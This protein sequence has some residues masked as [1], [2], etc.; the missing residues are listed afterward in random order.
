MAVTGG[1]GAFAGARGSVDGR[2]HD[3]RIDVTVR[4]VDQPPR[5]RGPAGSG[6]PS[7]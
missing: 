4:F 5:R 1:T 2:E 3:G 6:G 7:P